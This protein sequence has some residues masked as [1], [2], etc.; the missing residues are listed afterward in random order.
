MIVFSIRWCEKVVSAPP[1]ANVLII[2]N[3]IR[4]PTGP[5]TSI[6]TT[7]ATQPRRGNRCSSSD[8]RFERRVGHAGREEAA[9]RA[10]NGATTQ[11]ELLRVE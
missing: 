11:H 2:C 5:I 9:L 10:V 3:R 6:T 1:H 7:V 4:N 8:L